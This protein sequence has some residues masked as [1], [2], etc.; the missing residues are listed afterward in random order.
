MLGGQATACDKTLRTEK[1]KKGK[2]RKR[3]I[4]EGDLGE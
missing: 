1:W 2:R 4:E 3:S